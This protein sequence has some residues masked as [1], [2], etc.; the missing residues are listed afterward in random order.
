MRPDLRRLGSVRV[1]IT[2]VTT[3]AFAV[4]L[5]LAATMLVRTVRESTKRQIRHE[6]TVFL[7]RLG[8]KIADAGVQGALP[9]APPDLRYFV[10]DPSG[11]LIGGSG[12]PIAPGLVQSGPAVATVPPEGGDAVVVVQQAASPQGPVTLVAASPLDQV[13]RSVDALVRVL[14]FALPLLVAVV[15]FLAWLLVGRALKPVDSIRRKVEEISHTTLDRRLAIPS[16]NDE[17]VR[18]AHTMN[19]MLDRLQ[20]SAV[21]QREFVSDASH[22]LRSPITTIRAALEVALRHPAN[23]DWTTVGTRVLAEDARLEQI[24][25]E[26]LELA[27]TEEALGA[28]ADSIVELDDLVL[29]EAGRARSAG[30]VAVDAQRVS[31]AQVLGSATQLQRVVGNLV[32]NA[33]RHAT[34]RVEIALRDN[35]PR[36]ELT[37]DDDGPGIPPADRERIFDRFVRLGA[38]RERDGGGIGLGLAMVHSIVSRHGGTVRV[39]D[40]GLGGASF[41]VSLPSAAN[42][43]PALPHRQLGRF[44]A[45]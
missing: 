11:K 14:W 6:N 13:R 22:E 4:A 43:I 1:R 36:V 15:G 44:P 26:L 39:A 29:S 19:D 45:A 34:S 17:I 37:V 9:A 12:T 8:T 32:S 42:A 24:V 18:L 3:V 40:S 10:Y 5:G 27:R 16:G 23:T 2:L 20:T 25:A 41:V 33:L 35:G 7:D 28:P 38:S 21:R 31:G 30:P